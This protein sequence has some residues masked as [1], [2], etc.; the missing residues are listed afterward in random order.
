L[1]QA[2]WAEL[3]EGHVAANMPAGILNNFFSRLNRLLWCFEGAG[4]WELGY[5]TD[6]I[7]A[8]LLKNLPAKD[9]NQLTTQLANQFFQERQPST[10]ISRVLFDEIDDSSLMELPRYRDCLFRV[11]MFVE[12]EKESANVIFYEGRIYIIELSKPF[13]FFKGKTIKFGAVTQGNSKETITR[14]LDR[15]E[16]GR[17]ENDT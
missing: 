17:D 14:T 1:L 15:L 13:K 5:P 2:G 8:N 16:H 4:G 12:N 6:L 11:Q 9:A 3:Q 10:R 7:V